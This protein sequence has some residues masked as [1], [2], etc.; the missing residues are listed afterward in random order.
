MVIYQTLFERLGVTPEASDQEVKEAFEEWFARCN[1]DLDQIPSDVR[2]AFEFLGNAENRAYYRDLLDACERD[3]RLTF[4]PEKHR[5]LAR[6]C[7]LTEIVAYRDPNRENTFRFRRPDQPE[8]EWHQGTVERPVII[9]DESSPL[10]RFL[11]FQVFRRATPI[12][13]A[14]FAFL[15]A[16]LIVA[17]IGSL[18]WA[19]M[20]RDN[21]RFATF[22][23]G[24]SPAAIEQS[25]RKA[26]EQSI[27]A[28][29]PIAAASLK[30]LDEAA[31]KLRRDFKQV[32]GLELDGAD[33]SGVEKP[34]A[35][36]LAII[37]NDSVREAW[38]NL[39]A[40]RISREELE[41]RRK[42]VEA[43]GRDVGSG[44]FRAEDET[45]LQQ[46]IEWGQG[47]GEQMQSQARNI[48]HLRVMLAAET[49][50]MAGR[51]QERSTP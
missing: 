49:F 3:L 26:L 31:E 6:L 25:R 46:I 37:R 20:G 17:I 16:V 47:R 15:Y 35:L 7:H 39:L 21:S 8:P 34:R 22:A 19:I 30:S 33:K 12:Q 29:Q 28:K 45:T 1:G 9:R 27:L 43:I 42:N 10:I 38:T 36:D 23:V 11:L 2:D 5:S 48:E 44:T 50:E 51:E 18:E 13:K 4:T 40:S 14:G 32:V 41:A 24:P